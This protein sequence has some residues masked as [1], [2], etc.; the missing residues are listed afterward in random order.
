M[1]PSP[2]LARKLPLVVIAGVVM[3]SL[4]VA[5]GSRSSHL[6]DHRPSGGLVDDRLFGG[7]AGHQ[8]LDGQVV[9]GPGESPGDLVDKGQ[10][11]VG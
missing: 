7:K 6:G 9:D 5:E 11:V 1:E 4:A 10:G 8:G 2:A 3:F